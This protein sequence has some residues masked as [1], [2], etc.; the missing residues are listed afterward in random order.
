MANIA[1]T[2][3]QI[4]WW[5]LFWD[6]FTEST[7]FDLLGVSHARKEEKKKFIKSLKE[8]LQLSS[9]KFVLGQLS[10]Q[11]GKNFLN[12]LTA[13]GE[14]AAFKFAEQKIK[15]FRKELLNFLSS[16]VKAVI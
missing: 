7:V 9:I 12:L 2:R 6:D 5:D 15:N 8:Y 1:D 16:A 11:E 3:T 4:N 10:E 14:E 13:S